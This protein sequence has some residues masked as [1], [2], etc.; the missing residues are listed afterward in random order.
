[1]GL[2]LAGIVKYLMCLCSILIY[3]AGRNSEEERERGERREKQSQ[4]ARVLISICIT[5]WDCVLRMGLGQEDGS[6]NSCHS[7]APAY[8]VTASLTNPS[9]LLHCNNY[10]YASCVLTISTCCHFTVVWPRAQV[11]LSR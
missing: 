6:I 4:K 3:C 5:K 7:S 8:R 9:Q 2:N 10:S 1:M 11:S